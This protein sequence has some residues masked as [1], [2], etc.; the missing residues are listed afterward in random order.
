MVIAIL[1]Q[2]K[3]REN[4]SETLAYIHQYNLKVLL[5]FKS[6]VFFTYG[7]E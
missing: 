1:Q 2:C 3:W 5:K 4:T 7:L 6:E